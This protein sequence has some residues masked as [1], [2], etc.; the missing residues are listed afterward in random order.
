[1]PSGPRFVPTG[2]PAKTW[3]DHLKFPVRV[4]SPPQPP[5]PDIP[6][7][8]AWFDA[9]MCRN[10]GQQRTTPFC[11]NCG[12]KAA[13]RF[14]WRDLGKEGWERLRFFE[15]KS[16]RTL[17][18]L[19]TG[20]GRV[21]RAYVMGRRTVYMHPIALLIALVAILVAVLAVNKY[22][23]NYGFADSQVDAMAKRVVAYANWSFT[24]G[25]FAIFFGSWSVFRHRLGYNFVE[26][27]VLAVY[28]QA[29]ILAAI[30]LNLLPTLYWRDPAFIA[31]H[32]A[33]S[34]WYLYAI[35]LAVV[36]LAYRQF[37][38]LDL[39]RDWPRL[40]L[41]LSLYA[42]ASWLLLRA[43]AAAI[44]WLVTHG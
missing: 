3:R 33:W 37:F 25:I 44:L 11:P 40:A 20:P 34:A 13:P 42:A 27:G 9:A 30:I 2:M 22:F 8:T 16:V 21:A 43:Y 14:I 1:M 28:A 18:G 39:R 26:H 32:R 6:V 41:A 38:L 5:I 10:C 24:L 19:V 29:I 4:P 7:E 17:T 23:G 36:F 15:L 12:Q 31:A 35:K